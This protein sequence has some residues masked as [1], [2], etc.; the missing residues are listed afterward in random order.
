M[1][2]VV[3]GHYRESERVMQMPSKKV[4]TG[5]TNEDNV[6]LEKKT[7]NN[8]VPLNSG[9]FFFRIYERNNNL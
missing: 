3:T 5:M 8:L 6:P 2:N 7:Q 4:L 9:V 1:Y